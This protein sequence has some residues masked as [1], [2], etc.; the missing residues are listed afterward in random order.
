MINFMKVAIFIDGVHLS[1]LEKETGI[2]LDYGKMADELTKGEFRV[3]T[4]Y[5]D[6]KPKPADLHSTELKE[7]NLKKETFHAA[8]RKYPRF[9]I[10]LGRLQK[11]GNTWKQKGVD[12]RLG[13]DLVQMSA[14]K[15]ID[16]AYIIAADQD[17]VYAVDKAK[18][19]GVVVSLVQY[20]G[21]YTG[22]DLIKAVD[23]VIPINSAFVEKCQ[24]TM[25]NPSK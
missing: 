1:L 6:S 9:E 8:L 17:F 2:R 10:K 19:A 4:Y 16:K 22:A 24:F 12:M 15:H 11:F 25:S 3:R 18:E 20:P 21:D 14:S 7:L 23:E 5:Y 13:V